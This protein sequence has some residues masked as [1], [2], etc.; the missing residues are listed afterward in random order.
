LTV[1]LTELGDPHP[2]ISLHSRRH[3]FMNRIFTSLFAGSKKHQSNV[4]KHSECT[5]QDFTFARWRV[6]RMSSGAGT[7]C[8]LVYRYAFRRKILH[9]LSGLNEF[10]PEDWDNTFPRNVGIC[11]PMYTVSKKLIIGTSNVSSS[12]QV[13]SHFTAIKNKIILP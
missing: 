10:G 12:L 7:P 4:M 2:C 1:Q 13:R 5:V 8:S 11:L 6:F 9:S 3:E